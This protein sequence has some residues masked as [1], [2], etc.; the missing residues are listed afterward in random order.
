MSVISTLENGP[1][2]TSGILAMAAGSLGLTSILSRTNNSSTTH[3]L[4]LW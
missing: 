4:L 2:Y 1:A 3:T